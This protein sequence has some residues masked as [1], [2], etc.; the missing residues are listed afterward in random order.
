MDNKQFWIYL[1]IMAGSTYLIR[2]IPFAA[3]RKKIDNRSIQSF[4]YYIPYTVLT[5]M[6]IPAALYATQ[7]VISAAVGL[8]VAVGFSIKGKGLTTVAAAACVAVF[9]VELIMGWIC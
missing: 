1:L 7:S 9:A 5:A 2:V 8:L 6:T 3:I 4:L